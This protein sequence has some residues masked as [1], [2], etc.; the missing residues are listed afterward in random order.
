MSGIAELLITLGYRISGSDIQ[1]SSITERL[2]ALG[3]AVY[4]GHHRD[5]VTG[6]DVI[7]TSTAISPENPE[8][9]A[10]KASG[11]TDYSKG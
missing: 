5:N 2:E 7:V 4:P 6:A 3:A 11:H 1:M 10:A 8:V 9:S